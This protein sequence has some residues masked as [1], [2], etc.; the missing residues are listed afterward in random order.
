VVPFPA[1]GKQ[2][3]QDRKKPDEELFCWPAFFS[4]TY[5]HGG[6]EDI[7]MLESDVDDIGFDLPLSVFNF[8]CCTVSGL[9]AT[10]MTLS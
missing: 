10:T 4:I 6:A 1:A 2:R 8:G 7:S 9:R 5:Q 3:V